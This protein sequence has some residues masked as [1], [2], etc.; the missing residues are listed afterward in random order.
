MGIWVVASGNIVCDKCESVIG[1][2]EYDRK[3]GDFLADRVR[4]T[5]NNC[6]KSEAT[7]QEDEG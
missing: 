1:R 2:I 4:I 6:A 5:C 7:N 3:D